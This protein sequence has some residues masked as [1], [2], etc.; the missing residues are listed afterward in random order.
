MAK[1]SRVRALLT[2]TSRAEVP[3]PSQTQPAV[4]ALPTQQPSSSR[5]TKRARTSES[6]PNL[7]D[8]D[9]TV[10]PPILPPSPQPEPTNRTATRWVPKLTFKNR[11]VVD[12]DSVVAEKDH[13]LAF[14]LA[15]G[16]CLPKDMEHHRK[17]LNTELKSIRSATKSMILAI[18]KNYN[19]HKKV[20]ELRQTARDAVAEA[21]VKSAEVEK[22]KKQMAELQA[23]N[24]RLTGL[25]S[26][27]E[28]ERQKT[29][30]ALKDKYLHE[31]VKLERKKDAEIKEKQF[32]EGSDDEDSDDDTAPE[33]TSV[34]NADQAIQKNY[35]TH[36]KVL[37]LR[38]TARDAVAE[39]EVKSAEV[40]KI[41]KQMAELQAEN[42]RL[43]GLVSSAEAERQKTAIALKDKYLHEL[44]KL[45]RKK[46]AEIKEKQF[47]EG[48][49]DEDSD[50]DTAP[51]DTS[52]VNAD[53][54][55][56]DAA[57]DAEIEDLFS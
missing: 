45:E 39:A 1:K 24:S 12:A 23:E 8:E 48:S 9:E 19:T 38:Q 31:L 29:A 57:F 35:N 25:V 53:Q 13:E 36:K 7:V 22:I 16:V 37:E 32:L 55:D 49:D 40:E 56:A 42:S 4:V 28:A 27:A 11:D 50:D 14:N 2:E 26:S 6:E 44:V 52:V 34:V 30:I 21:E 33:D 10:I 18:Q 17:Q 15:K 46:D 54:V 20:L 3:S 41:K 47:L 5:R 51:E 43:T